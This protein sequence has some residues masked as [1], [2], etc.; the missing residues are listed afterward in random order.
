MHVEGG[1]CRDEPSA[2]ILWAP[3]DGPGRTIAST[4]PETD[5]YA[6]A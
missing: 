6:D 3:H 4:M 5:A 2:P 1:S